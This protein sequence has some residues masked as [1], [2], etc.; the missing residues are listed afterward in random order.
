MQ[1]EIQQ[2]NYYM[3]TK[4]YVAATSRTCKNV[5]HMQ[6]MASRV[7]FKARTSTCIGS[8]CVCMNESQIAFRKM[9]GCIPSVYQ[10]V[11]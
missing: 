11:F 4:K 7:H 1:T 5:H 2:Q 6:A 9:Q 3:C 8:Q 10:N